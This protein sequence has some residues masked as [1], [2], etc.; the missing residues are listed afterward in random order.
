MKNKTTREIK[1]IREN[2]MLEEK[3]RR[4]EQ[5]LKIIGNECQQLLIDLEPNQSE[6]PCK[7]D[8]WCTKCKIHDE[9]LRGFHEYCEGCSMHW[10]YVECGCRTLDK[11]EPCPYFKEKDKT[12][13]IESL[14]AH[15]IICSDGYYPYCSNCKTEPKSGIMSKYCPECGRR[16]KD[17]R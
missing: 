15:W 16:M 13:P 3:L 12:E 1:L 4:Y 9:C 7:S 5:L 17:G 14:T 10:D 8:E 11:N 6:T 2:A